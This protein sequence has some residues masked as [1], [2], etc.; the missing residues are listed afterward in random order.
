MKINKNYQL[1]L[2]SEADSERFAIHI[3]DL[4]KKFPQKFP[5][6]KFKSLVLGF[7]GDIGMGKTTIIRKLLTSMGVKDRIKSPTFSIVES[8]KLA[9]LCFHHFDLYRIHE[10]YELDYIGFRDYFINN[11]ISCIEWPENLGDYSLDLDIIFTISRHGEGRMI[12]CRAQTQRG[13]DILETWV[14]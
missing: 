13:S 11:T 14:I 12:N 10:A 8:Y 3:A 7:S 1:I 5:E 9:N 2:S 6:N 4:L